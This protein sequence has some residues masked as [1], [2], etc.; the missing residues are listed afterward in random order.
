MSDTRV[1]DVHDVGL[2]DSGLHVGVHCAVSSDG[3][4]KTSLSLSLFQS[5]SVSVAAVKPTVKPASEALRVAVILH[6]REL[7]YFITT[8]AGG[9][10]FPS[11]G[12]DEDCDESD[13]TA[14]AFDLFAGV[15]LR[16]R[17]GVNAQASRTICQATSHRSMR[18]VG[19]S[20]GS[21]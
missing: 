6:D 10:T 18:L 4:V 14:K 2:D 17:P 12:I 5:A 20:T 7:A 8:S 1:V 15:S 16:K 3:F 11:H 19:W 9:Y 13:T 21:K